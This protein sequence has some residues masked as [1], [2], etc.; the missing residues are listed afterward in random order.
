MVTK[1]QVKGSAE[2][3]WRL[4][5]IK[6]YG[7]TLLVVAFL[8]AAFTLIRSTDTVHIGILWESYG[9]TMAILACVLLP[10]ILFDLWHYA[11]IVIGWQHY[12][13]YTVLLDRPG[14]SGIYRG[15]VYYTVTFTAK[16]GETVTMDTKPLW[17]SGVFALFRLEEYNNKQV[18]I[19]YDPNQG[20][21][22]VLGLAN[23]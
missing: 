13:R 10:F 4:N 22:V 9:I 14:T 17:S 7:I 12:E 6:M 8:V 2:A 5:Q 1:E 11:K 16:D 23:K 20:R 19:L 18:D 21:I 15:A 3:R